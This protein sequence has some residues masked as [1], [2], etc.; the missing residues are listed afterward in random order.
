MFWYALIFLM[1]FGHTRIILL[2]FYQD[3]SLFPDVDK[4]FW[5]VK[6]KPHLKSSLWYQNE[7]IGVL[8]PS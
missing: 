6:D 8:N 4:D 2:V 5:K 7:E 1:L 3:S